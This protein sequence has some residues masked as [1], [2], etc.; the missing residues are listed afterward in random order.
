MTSPHLVLVGMMGSGK[1]T[2]GQILAARLERAF[3]DSDAHVEARTGRTVRQIFATDGEAAY[4]VLETESLVQALADPRPTVIAAAGGVVLA[5]ANRDA[6]RAADAVV[7]WI[8]APNAVLVE[9]ATR[10]SHRPALDD[11]PLRMFESMR[12]RRT[13]LY[14]EVSDH[15]IEIGDD[16][17]QRVA[18][19]VL[20]AVEGK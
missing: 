2:V 17:P 9:R 13:A 4:R 20:D 6:L 5:S 10:G 14:D 15:R 16:S 18:D 19:R 8:D 11:D 1:T 3:V 7:V 12:A